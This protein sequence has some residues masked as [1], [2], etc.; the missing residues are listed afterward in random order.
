MRVSVAIA[1]IASAHSNLVRVSWQMQ[2]ECDRGAGGEMHAGPRG[3]DYGNLVK[4]YPG[5]RRRGKV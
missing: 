1:A 2:W 5:Q 3:V 4:A